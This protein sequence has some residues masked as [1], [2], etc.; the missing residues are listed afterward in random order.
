MG[1]A[2]LQGIV[3]LGFP[4]TLAAVCPGPAG[5]VRGGGAG[6]VSMASPVESRTR[7]AEAGVC[8]DG[9][10]VAH[11]AWRSVFDDLD[12]DGKCKVAKPQAFTE[13]VGDAFVLPAEQQDRDV[14]VGTGKSTQVSGVHCIS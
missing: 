1:V 4:S 8:A 13:A 10:G 2:T 3:L 12:G 6:L 14:A 5:A 11:R 9:A 7:T